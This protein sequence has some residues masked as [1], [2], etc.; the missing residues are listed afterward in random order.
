LGLQLRGPRYFAIADLVG[1]HLFDG[2]PTCSKKPPELLNRQ[3]SV[4]RNTAHRECIH[5]IV[6]RNGEN[7]AAVGHH[8]VLAFANDLEPG[9]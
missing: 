3:A 2:H 7:A 6:A 4:L 1:V 8:D 9:F 5:G